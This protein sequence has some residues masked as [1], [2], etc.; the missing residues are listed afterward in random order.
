MNKLKNG[1]RIT[2]TRISTNIKPLSVVGTVKKKLKW[3]VYKLNFR[4][5][6]SLGDRTGKK[7]PD[8]QKQFFC[9]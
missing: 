6:N 8:F 3:A 5:F 1:K 7:L 2:H 9:F 4:T